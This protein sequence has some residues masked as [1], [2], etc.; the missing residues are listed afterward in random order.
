MILSDLFW[1]L[2]CEHELKK[3]EKTLHD[4]EEYKALMRQNRQMLDM[5]IEETRKDIEEILKNTMKRA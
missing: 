1:S 2:K 3:V 4:A 5:N